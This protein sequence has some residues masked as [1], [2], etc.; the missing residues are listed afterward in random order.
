MWW[1]WE[2]AAPSLRRSP[3]PSPSRSIHLQCAIVLTTLDHVE[4]PENIAGPWPC[5]V[6]Y[7][8]LTC[9]AFTWQERTAHAVPA[10]GLRAECAEV[11][12]AHDLT[13]LETRSFSN[14]PYLG[15]LKPE[16]EVLEIGIYRVTA[17]GAG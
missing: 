15:Y 7:R 2:D 17:G 4:D 13:P 12:D 16:Q 1:R 9:H 5:V 3:V 10:G 8:G 14:R 6:W 11:E